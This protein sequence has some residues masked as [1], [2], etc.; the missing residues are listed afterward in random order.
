MKDP[1]HKDI[2]YRVG[3]ILDIVTKITSLGSIAPAAVVLVAWVLVVSVFII[4]RA[5]FNVNWMFIEEFT[6]YWLIF[7]VFF[8]LAYT[9][10]TGWHVK[11]D[12]LVRLLPRRTR[13]ILAIVTN[14]MALIIII[15][16]TWRTAQWFQSGL[17][18]EI[19]S[20]FPSN[21]LLWPVYLVIPVGLVFMGLEML[22]QIYNS[23]LG[24]LRPKD[25][26]LTQD[27]GSELV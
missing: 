27:D 12:V 17:E 25:S 22:R 1:D 11:V 13:E 16:L 2:S 24:V 26:S 19:H 5:V 6:V 23:I 3:R 21:I 7:I 20:S 8:G 10:R 15:Y 14:F 9:L 4:G 18:Y